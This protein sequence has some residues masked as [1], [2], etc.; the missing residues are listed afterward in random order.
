MRA[1]NQLK[2]VK[3]AVESC[4]NHPASHKFDMAHLGQKAN[5][6]LYD[7]EKCQSEDLKI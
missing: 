6:E 1:T 2:E 4:H 7:R 5:Y 3:L